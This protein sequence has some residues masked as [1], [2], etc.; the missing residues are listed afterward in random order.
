MTTL[1]H[2]VKQFFRAWQAKVAP[3]ELLMLREYLSSEQRT[4]FNRMSLSDQRHSLD[5]FY[6]LRDKGETDD[7]LLQTALLHDVGKSA[8]RIH[9]WQRVAY[10][11]MGKVS[12]RWR[13]RFC[14]QPQRDWRYAFF[15]LAHHMEIGAALANRAGCA[16]EVV[17]LIRAHQ[18]PITPKIPS[19]A[20]RKLRALQ[21]AD[22]Q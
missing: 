5:L 16:D 20:R 9:L 8:A 2:R 18:S 12:R 15:V 1:L 3:P 21:A 11:V 22:N 14:D 19:A 10:V 7:A 6:T 4:L 13:K 17:E